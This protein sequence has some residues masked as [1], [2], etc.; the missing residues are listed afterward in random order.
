MKKYR[1]I[2]LSGLIIV[3][4]GF[5]ANPGYQEEYRNNV[6]LGRAKSLRTKIEFAVGNLN[7]HTCSE[8]LSQGIY[9]YRRDTWRP[10][11]SYNDGSETGY[12]NIKNIDDRHQFEYDDSDKTVWDISLNDKV[13]NEVSISMTAGVANINFQ[14]SN[15]RRFEFEMAAGESNINLRNTSVP[16]ISFKAIAGE[17][18]LDLSGRWK[19]DLEATIKGG[20][21][22]LTII[23]PPD[24]GVKM[25][26]T[27]ILG[28]VDAPQFHEDDNSYTNDLYGRTGASLYLDIT[29]GIGDINVETTRIY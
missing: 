6:K 16:Y 26:I 2:L 20:V 24:I 18:E 5:A 27:G 19:N 10:E 28:D 11:I 12:L 15:L 9:S 21:G 25:D 4:S 7:V 22:E 17:A 23:L 14:N 1:I 29:G 13:P 8:F 3:F